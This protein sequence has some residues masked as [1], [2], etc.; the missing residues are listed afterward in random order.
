M[1][2]STLAKL[3]FHMYTNVCVC[4]HVACICVQWSQVEVSACMHV[5]LC[6]YVCVYACACVRV[7]K[8]KVDIPC[9]SQLLFTFSI[10]AEVSVSESGASQF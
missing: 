4:M 7:C 8:P 2:L 3:I 10:E 6:V 5:C 9:V 1:I